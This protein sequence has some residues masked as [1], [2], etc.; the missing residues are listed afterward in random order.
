MFRAAEKKLKTLVHDVA[1]TSDELEVSRGVF[2][3]GGF[4][5]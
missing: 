1:L 4:E 2:L 3:Q 5:K